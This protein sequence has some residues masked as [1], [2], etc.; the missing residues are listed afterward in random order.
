MFFFSIELM[1]SFSMPRNLY[2][3]LAPWDE[4]AEN[5]RILLVYVVCLLVFPGCL[6]SIRL[7]FLICL[8]PS[9]SSSDTHFF[10]SSILLQ[11]VII[12]NTL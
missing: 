9:H 12:K 2:Q 8:F 6:P 4:D 1:F 10:K 5:C 7:Y 3:P 11:F